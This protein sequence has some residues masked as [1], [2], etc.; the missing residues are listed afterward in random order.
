MHVRRHRDSPKATASLAWPLQLP[1]GVC[2]RAAVHAAPAATVQ[3]AD[4]ANATRRPMPRVSIAFHN[5]GFQVR[6]SFTANGTGSWRPSTPARHRMT[7]VGSAASRAWRSGNAGEPGKAARRGDGLPRR[8]AKPPLRPLRLRRG[9]AVRRHAPGLQGRGHT[10]VPGLRGRD[11]EQDLQPGQRRDRA[12]RDTKLSA[13][14]DRKTPSTSDPVAAERP[15]CRSPADWRRCH[16]RATA[17][18]CSACP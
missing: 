14:P 1:G 11:G 13:R 15:P 8:A 4:P 3:P 7:S 6:A 18:A 9:Q 17:R 2:P 12:C 5:C 10:G 16:H